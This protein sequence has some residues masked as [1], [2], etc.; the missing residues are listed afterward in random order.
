MTAQQTATSLE[1]GVRQ[2]WPTGWG[3]PGRSAR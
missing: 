1:A 2:A 3:V